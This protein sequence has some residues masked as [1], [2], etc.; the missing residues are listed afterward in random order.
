MSNTTNS[1]DRIFRLAANLKQAE[2]S[3]LLLTN[4]VNMGYLTGF[5]EGGGE[6][7]SA[8]AISSSGEER[9]ICPALS[10]NQAR[11]CGI[12]D[13]RPWRDGE[14]PMVHF[15]QLVEDWSLGNANVAVDDDMPAC[16]LLPIQAKA[17]SASYVQ[18][19]KYMADLMRIKDSKEIACLYKAAE[20]AD[21]AWDATLPQLKAGMTERQV[22]DI[23]GASMQA[24]GG[25]V[26][27]CIAAA[28]PNSAEPHHHPDD[29]VVK[30][31]EIL[32]MDFGCSY[33]GYN[34]DI[35]RTVSIGKATEE[36]KTVYDIVHKAHMAGRGI[37]KEGVECQLVDRA[38]RAVID[39]AGYGEYFV[40]RTGHGVGT[41]IHEEPYIIEGNKQILENGHCFSDEPGIYLA[42]N[43]GVRI[44]NILHIENGVAKSFNA[45]PSP[46]LIETE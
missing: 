7:F 46:S 10:E 5:T 45:E 31:G 21:K 6:R 44:E 42:G 29:T 3:A 13:V 23:L 28:G 34:S 37:A 33:K 15:S 8:L 14:D 18:G 27:F 24:Q 26:T 22:A 39:A 35:T 17:P 19:S 11:R 20:M 2:M 43:F 41:S 4:P 30:E 1:S 40:H 16:Y 9:M 25:V 38:A 36:M 12:Q 32:L